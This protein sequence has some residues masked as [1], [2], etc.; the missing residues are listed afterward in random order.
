MDMLCEAPYLL[1]RPLNSYASLTTS[2]QKLSAKIISPCTV[3]KLYHILGKIYESKIHFWHE[4][5]ETSR[6]IMVSL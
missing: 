6:W 5:Y 3:S 2:N 4:K 1:S